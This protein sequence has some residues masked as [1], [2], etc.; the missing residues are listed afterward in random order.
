MEPTAGA[1]TFQTSGDAYDSFMGR[2][3]QPLASHFADFARVSASQSVL[4]VGC[5]PGAL[6]AVL[7]ER[8]GAAAVAACDPS[9]SFVAACTARYP[10]V[11]VREGRAEKLPFGDARFDAALAQLVLHFVS[12]PTVAAAELRRVVR[13]KGIVAACVW[14]FAEGMQMLRC[15]WDAALSVDPAAPDEARTLRFGREHEIAELFT[16]AGFEDVTETTIEVRSTYATFD[17]LWSGFL[18]GVGPAG[19]YCLSLPDEQRV[20]VRAKLLQ[21]V[22]SP[23]GPFTLAA[24]ARAAKGIVPG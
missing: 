11:E 13:P 7:V 5:G 15:F 4:D 24:V 1:K 12:E 23:T 10:G 20:A 9:P 2:Y 18:A 21:L 3:S 8:I 16:E 19:A 17:D 6:T 14:D 22:G